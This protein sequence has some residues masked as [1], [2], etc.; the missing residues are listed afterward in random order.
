MA[1]PK[2][3]VT[4]GAGFVGQRLIA[5]LLRAQDT[6]Q[7]GLPAF[8][9]VISLDLAP[10]AVVDGR[11]RSV[12]GDIADP[13]LLDR[14][15]SGDVSVI[16]HLAAVVSGQAEADFDLGMRINLDG[17]RAL[18][19]RTRHLPAVPKLVFSSSVA[20]FGGELPPTV[21]EEQEL[22]PTTSYGTQK[23][24]GELLV[25]D[26]TRKGF[27][28]GRV[29]RLPTVVVRPGEPNAA[30]SSFASGIIRE[31]FAGLEAICPV[32]IETRLWLASPDTVVAN[33][34]HALALPRHVG[35][36]INLPGLSVSVEQMLDS[37]SRI[38]GATRRALVRQEP[39]ARISAIVLGWP[40][41][42]VVTRALALGFARDDSLDAV[43][44]QYATSLGQ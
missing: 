40:N 43:I 16:Y 39:D 15:V 13:V 20:V 6:G 31:P 9:Q 24:I 21:G 44:R 19:D 38:G 3:I 29:V 18:L 33:L 35:R 17:T 26:C 25:A 5:A 32:P 37:L 36:A 28:D 22:R 42:F 2:I 34:L 27:V 12:V 41:D 14:H 10:S 23:A 11:V 8:D 4:G 30:A 1:S 7:P